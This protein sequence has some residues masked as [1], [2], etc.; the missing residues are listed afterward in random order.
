[1]LCRAVIAYKSREVLKRDG[2]TLLYWWGNIH[3][4]CISDEVTSYSQS[5]YL[6]ISAI[7]W[8]LLK[9][10]VWSYRGCININKENVFLVLFTG[11]YRMQELQENSRRSRNLTFI[12][13]PGSAFHSRDNL[14]CVWLVTSTK[15]IC[16]NYSAMSYTAIKVRVSPWLGKSIPNNTGML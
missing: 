11:Q 16:C 5:M 13:N 3:K 10:H 9:S 4:F 6:T 7:I 15:R 2:V 14:I 1:M 12:S 8:I